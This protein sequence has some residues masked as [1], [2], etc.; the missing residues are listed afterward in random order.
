MSVWLVAG[1]PN[2]TR[3]GARHDSA[4]AQLSHCQLDVSTFCINR[5]LKFWRFRPGRT[6]IN[7]SSAQVYCQS[8]RQ[9]FLRKC[10]KSLSLAISLARR[11]SLFITTS[12]CR[13]IHIQFDNSTASITCTLKYNFE[14]VLAHIWMENDDY[15]MYLRLVSL[16]RS[17]ASPLHFGRRKTELLIRNEQRNSFNWSSDFPFVLFSCARCPWIYL[18]VFHKSFA[19]HFCFCNILE[20]TRT[21]G[22]KKCQS[23]KS[24]ANAFR[25]KWVTSEYCNHSNYKFNTL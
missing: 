4:V 24:N 13:F 12:R 18:N 19:L 23:T 9:I 14:T 10:G 20:N 5:K 21:R 15:K 6:L 7:F 17:F 22:H 11:L 1:A 3:N 2:C 16:A 25:F 8:L